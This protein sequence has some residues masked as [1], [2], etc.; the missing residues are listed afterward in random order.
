MKLIKTFKSVLQENQE[1]MN[2]DLYFKKEW[3][4]MD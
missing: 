3:F 1:S 2:P 4:L